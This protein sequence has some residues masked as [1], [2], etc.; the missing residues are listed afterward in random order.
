MLHHDKYHEYIDWSTSKNLNET[1]TLTQGHSVAIPPVA[2]KVLVLKPT[3]EIWT[4]H[5]KVNIF[6]HV[7]GFT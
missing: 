5:A 7:K 1:N 3:C 4:Q 2:N 6:C